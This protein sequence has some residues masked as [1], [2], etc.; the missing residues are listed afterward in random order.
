MTT[1]FKPLSFDANG[2]HKLYFKSFLFTTRLKM[3]GKS[4]I[5]TTK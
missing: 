3:N 2:N 5:I 4:K 1:F